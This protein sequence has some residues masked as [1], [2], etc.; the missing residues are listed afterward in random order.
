MYHY[1]LQSEL[2]QAVC[3]RYLLQIGLSCC[4]HLF[5]YHMVTLSDVLTY[6]TIS[7]HADSEE[8]VNYDSYPRPFSPSA[9]QVKSLACENEGFKVAL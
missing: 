2:L 8:Q 4:I 7:K 3:S 5:G 6:V 9:C 1:H